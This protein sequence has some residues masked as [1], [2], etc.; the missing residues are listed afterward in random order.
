MGEKVAV[1]GEKAA[2]GDKIQGEDIVV[3]EEEESTAAVAEKGY[4]ANVVDTVRDLQGQDHILLLGLQM[5]MR[6]MVG[7]R[8]LELQGEGGL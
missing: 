7:R 2:V 3:G 5:E 1:D 6:M 8:A 4:G